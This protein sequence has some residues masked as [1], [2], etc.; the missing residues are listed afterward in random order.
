M[1]LLPIFA[2]SVAFDNSFASIHLVWDSE[3]CKDQMWIDFQ[4]M[5]ATP[6]EQ[7]PEYLKEELTFE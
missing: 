1:D 2:A 5:L 4:L 7:W 6:P 3:E